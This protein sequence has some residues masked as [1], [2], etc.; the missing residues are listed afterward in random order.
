MFPASM[1]STFPPTTCARPA[2]Q[3]RIAAW[4]TSVPTT[5]CGV[6]RKIA[7]SMIAITVPLPAELRPITKPVVAPIATAAIL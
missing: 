6:R 7:I 2:A 1:K 3:S 5:R 4:K